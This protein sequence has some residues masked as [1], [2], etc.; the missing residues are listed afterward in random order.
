MIKLSEVLKISVASIQAI[1]A[2]CE[3]VLIETQKRLYIVSI[4]EKC[5]V[6]CEGIYTQNYVGLIVTNE[7]YNDLIKRLGDL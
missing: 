2:Q 1:E 7:F 5:N 3:C 6:N 4:G